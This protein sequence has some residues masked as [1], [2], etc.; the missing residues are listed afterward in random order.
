MIEIKEERSTREV[1]DR[2]GMLESLQAIG[3][4]LTPILLVLPF[5]ILRIMDVVLAYYI[6]YTVY[7]LGTI[8]ILKF[9]N[10]KLQDIGI[11]TKGLGQS[12]GGSI[13]FVSIMIIIFTVREGLQL[14]TEL[15]LS[16]I[17]E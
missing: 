5:I 8:A 7:I 13:L 15:S 2:E 3:L 16:K 11:S 14:T 9:N 6:I 1:N 10:K 4:F 17:I 12:L